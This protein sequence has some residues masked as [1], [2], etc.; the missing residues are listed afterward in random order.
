MLVLYRWGLIAGDSVPGMLQNVVVVM[1][2]TVVVSVVTYYLVERPVM[3]A[4]KR[5]R[6]KWS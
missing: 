4:A 6:S 1:A 2:V 3:N 5:Y